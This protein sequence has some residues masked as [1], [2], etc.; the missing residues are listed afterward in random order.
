[1]T[2]PLF[3][4]FAE[5]QLQRLTVEELKKRLR[6]KLG[7]MVRAVKNISAGNLVYRGVPWHCRPDLISQVSYPP[8]DKVDQF[9]RLNRPGQS[10]FYASCAPPGVFYELKAREGDRIAFSE[11]E[12]MK[13]L[14]IHDLGYHSGALARLGATPNSMRRRL[15]EP[16]PD[17]TQRN[18]RLRKK[19]ALAFTVDVTPGFEYRYKQSVALTEFW[20]EHQQDLP[21]YPDGPQTSEVAGIVYPSLQMRGDA[22][23]V[24]FW[25]KFVHSSL[26]LRHVQ[27]V[28]VEKADYARLAFSFFSL[29]IACELVGGTSIKW[30]S[31]LP[32]EDARRCHIALENGKWVQRDGQG[33]I[34]G[35]GP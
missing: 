16:I 29:D 7:G 19:V 20:C 26:A 6:M 24:A 23:N 12:V 4:L 2:T 32:S 34:Y 30:R 3:P 1:V 8:L 5:A 31:D 17:E 15:T 33:N 22:D 21:I 28:L 18:G 10:V 9:G 14:W 35:T 13:P 25:P 11:W 27:Y